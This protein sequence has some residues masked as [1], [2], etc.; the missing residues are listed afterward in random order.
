MVAIVCTKASVDTWGGFRSDRVRNS[1]KVTVAD[2]SAAV[3]GWSGEESVR[4]FTTP[5]CNS[6]PNPR[7]GYPHRAAAPAPPTAPD[8]LLGGPQL[9]CGDQGQPAARRPVSA[10]APG[11]RRLQHRDGGAAHLRRKVIGEAVGPWHRRAA[12][13]RLRLRDDS[14]R[15]NHNVNI[16]LGERGT[17]G[18]RYPAERF[19][20]AV[21]AIL[22]TNRGAFEAIRDS[23]GSQ[24]IDQCDS[25]R[26]H[27]LP[28]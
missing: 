6:A 28:A 16:L 8:A 11:I 23:C 24:P 19:A 25:G 20:S 18:W 22:F 13:L 12:R 4:P 15:A 14:R 17:S 1:A 27:V 10:T 21:P 2:A 5:P 3:P 26:A 9:A 7:S